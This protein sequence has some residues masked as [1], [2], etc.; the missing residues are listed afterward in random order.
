MVPNATELQ[1]LIIA[2][3]NGSKMARQPDEHRTE[4]NGSVPV[5]GP[6]GGR[7]AAG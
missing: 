1:P 4:G 7:P 3:V 5:T 2:S 6:N